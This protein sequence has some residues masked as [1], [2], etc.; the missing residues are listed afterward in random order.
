MGLD[1]ILEQ[2]PHPAGPGKVCHNKS[3]GAGL[4][5][6]KEDVPRPRNDR[7]HQAVVWVLAVTA[8][9]PEDLGAGEPERIRAGE[10]IGAGED[11]HL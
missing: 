7:F 9:M 1:A 8:P 3:L 2:G 6:L 5:A 11:G 10:L 4:I